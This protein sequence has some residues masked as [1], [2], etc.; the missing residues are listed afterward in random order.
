MESY[1]DC[2]ANGNSEQ[3]STHKH[4]HGDHSHHHQNPKHGEPGHDHSACLMQGKTTSEAIDPVCGMKVDPKTAK[5]GSSEYKGQS[6]YF[7][8]PK[9]K[10]KFDNE[11]EKYLSPKK[12]QSN[13]P[14]DVEYTCPMHPEIKQIGPG[15]CPICGMALEPTVL[16]ADHQE[17]QTE[18]LDMRKRFIF[19][20]VLSIPLLLISMGGRH[21]ISSHDSQTWMNYLEFALATPVVLWGG[22]P[23]FERFWMSL[24]TRNLNMFTLIGLGVGIAYLFSLFGVFMPNLF[25]ESMKNEH[26]GLVN[27]YFE[28]AAVIVALVLLGQVL[29]LK[30]RSQTSA[31]IK[32]LL[33]LSP[34]TAR[35]LKADGNYEEVPLDEI[36]VGDRLQV[37]PG[38]KVPVDGIVISGNS[39]IDESMV[40][41]ESIAVEKETGSNV[42]G[43]TINGTGSLVI[44][45]KKVGRE[46]LLAQ[47]IQMV[48]EAQRSKAPIQKLADTVSGYFVP[49]VVLASVLTAVVW[50]AVG[51]DPKLANAI[52][53]AIAVLII[54][55]P[56][57]LGLATPM[58]IMVAT[59]KAAKQGILFKD[60]SAIEVLRK[61]QVLIVDKT[62]TLTEGKPKVTS[63]KTFGGFSEEEIFSF[64]GSL[65]RESEHPLAHAIYQS[66]KDKGAS[67]QAVEK[68]ASITGKGASGIVSG[69]WIHIGNKAL[70]VENS[71][72]LSEVEKTAD[73]LRKDGQT[74]MFVSVDKKIAALIGVSDPIK[75]T[76]PEALKTLRQSGLKIVMVTGDNKITAQAVAAKLDLDDVVADVLPHQ[77]AEIVKKYQSQGYLVGMAGDGINDAP[78]LAQAEVGIAMGTGTDVAMKSAGVTLVKGDLNGIAKS[79]ELSLETIANIKQNLFFAFFY[80]ALGVPVAAGV[81]FPFFGILLS[82]VFAAAAMSLSSV[83]VIANA[84]RLGKSKN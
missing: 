35:R 70:M 48:S 31:A 50:Y 36:K 12:E 3:N 83:S 67:F 15:S 47:I 80:N 71:I 1:K 32:A 53:N 24:K 73:E 59:G 72:I 5:G 46:T 28:P 82:P 40:T 23:F 37:R 33:G 52:V 16:T 21:L 74:M 63:I 27:L 78:G 81:L 49:I 84:L 41:G 14:L 77:K 38:E 6:Y 79:R 64:A 45:A 62:G 44:E 68:F 69:K 26:T 2:C 43:A 56:C 75:E 11:P 13:L 34:K 39:S 76:T 18:Y 57:A 10:V 4:A 29:E 65:E 22:W 30:A 51:P 58:S 54:A 17:D 66:A 19:S 61:I 8:N 20:V 7:C 9:C 55:C 42:I 60:A 25:P